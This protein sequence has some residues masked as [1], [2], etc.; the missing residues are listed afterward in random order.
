MKIFSNSKTL[1]V[2][3]CT[4]LGIVFSAYPAHAQ[5]HLWSQRFGDWDRELGRSVH[6]DSFGNCI[7][8]GYFNSTI[9]LGGGTLTSA[10][11]ADIFLAKYQ[12]SPQC[13][14]DVSAWILRDYPLIP[15]M[16]VPQMVTV[17]L[18]R[19]HGSGDAART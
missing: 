8:T 16:Q 11:N 10:G 3:M 15:K 5:T 13:L 19:D 12:D 2:I 14:E 18:L 9:D 17:R 1:L 7:M 6:I 4:F